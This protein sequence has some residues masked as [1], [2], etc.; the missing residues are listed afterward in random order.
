MADVS[1]AAGDN[2]EYDEND[3][4][5]DVIYTVNVVIIPAAQKFGPRSKG[6]Y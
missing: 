5:V 3:Y 4:C 6:I 2:R 1:P